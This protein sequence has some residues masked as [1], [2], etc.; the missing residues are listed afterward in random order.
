MGPRGIL[1]LL[2]LL[3]IL[4]LAITVVLNPGVLPETAPAADA[5]PPRVVTAAELSRGR[6]LYARPDPRFGCVVCHGA[7]A[8]GTSMGPPLA[9]V[10][11]VYLEEYGGDAAKA[12][13]R[14]LA[15]LRDP[16]SYP[17]IRRH[18]QRFLAPMPAYRA[19]EVEELAALASHLMSLRAGE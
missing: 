13:E 16:D 19:L 14:F 6:E 17:A 3:L 7:R 2:L 9:G 18:G 10:A 15:H 4:A 11:D 8:E 12:R 5:P 1:S